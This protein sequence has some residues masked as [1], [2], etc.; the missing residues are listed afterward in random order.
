M[1]LN[2]QSLTR[3]R[4][5]GLGFAALLASTA[6]I[7]VAQTEG[8]TRPADQIDTPT[9]V[10]PER[11]MPPV[12]RTSPSEPASGATSAGAAE[13]AIKDWP[14]ETQSQARML[15]ERYGQPAK[16]DAKELVWNDNGPWRKTTLRREGFTPSTMGKD[17]DHLEQ[18][19]SYQVPSAKI[20]DIKR[21]DKRIEVNEAANELTSRADTES[22]NYLALNLADDIAKGQ[23][24]VQGARVFYQ[25]VKMLERAGKSSPYLDGFIFTM[26]KSAPDSKSS[27]ESDKSSSE[28]G[29]GTGTEPATPPTSEPVT[30]PTSEPV[31]P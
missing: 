7:A 19:I 1:M 16:A 30:P 12:E 23:R 6:G 8:Q 31:T 3:R 22:M 2:L 4:F 13:A 17:R 14:K 27:S 21:F 20:A 24:S 5:A 18:V 11:A 10:T 28:S 15:I 29:T 26:D 9:T 25:K